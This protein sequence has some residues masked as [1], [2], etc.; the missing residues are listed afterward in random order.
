M[1]DDRP[2]PALRLEQ[3]RLARGFN[4]AKEA[5]TYFGW[6]YA[7]Y[8]QHESGERGIT[9]AAKK[10]AHAYRVSEGW[11]L[12]G[13]GQGP[14]GTM[15][16]PH[17][18]PYEESRRTKGGPVNIVPGN[19]LVLADRMPVYAAAKGGDGHIIVTFDPVDYVKRPAELEHVKGGYGLLIY[20]DSM[21]PAFWDG[22]MALVNPNLPAMRNKNVVLYHTPPHGGDAEAIVK[23]LNGW[24]DT[25]WILQQWNPPMEFREFRQEWPI[26]H[27]V[28]GKYDAR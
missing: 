14:D 5:A 18:V 10:Y 27:R 7:T 2:E 21:I 13:E 28:V 11:L 16:A 20:G 12:T 25:E 17:I 9:R 8:A 19:S 15:A 22:D 23:Q 3:A 26:C 1:N 4:N 24:T 6:P